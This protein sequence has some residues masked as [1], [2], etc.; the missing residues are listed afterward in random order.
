M[1]TSEDSRCSKFYLNGYARFDKDA[2]SFAAIASISSRVS[3]GFQGELL[4]DSRVA[5]TYPVLWRTASEE[6]RWIVDLPISTWRSIA[7]VVGCTAAELR[8][9]T[10]AA[11]HASYHFLWRRVLEPAGQL[12]W[13]L[14]RGSIECNLRALAAEEHEPEEPCSRQF[15]LLLNREVP[16]PMAQLVETVELLGQVS[17]S[18][19]P[20]EQQ[21][22][23]LA[24]LHRWH[25][26][27]EL[28]TL[29]FRALC[30]QMVRLLPSES[31]ADRQIS[32]IVRQMKKLESKVPERAGAQHMVL[33][34]ILAVARGRKVH[35]VWGDIHFTTQAAQ[36]QQCVLLFSGEAVVW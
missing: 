32:K 36:T 4:E 2:R 33:K 29:V 25:P 27:Y 19:L 1:H 5:A 24:A 20:A 18:S 10:I 9:D 16:Y 15:W 17:W 22:G 30:H 11:S 7:S 12:P 21:H 35:L 26:E 6:L 14:C 23:S 8:D 28:E 13:R 34:A 3:E 31:Q